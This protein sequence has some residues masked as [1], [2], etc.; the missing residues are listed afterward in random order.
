VVWFNR[1]EGAHDDMTP[2]TDQAPD[3]QSQRGRQRAFVGLVATSSAVAA[4]VI[5]AAQQQPLGD[6]PLA[7]I[8]CGCLL[9]GLAGALRLARSVPLGLASMV[10]FPAWALLDLAMNGGHNLLPLELAIYAVYGGLG[11]AVAA[12]AKRCRG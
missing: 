11:V 9:A 5:G 4:I 3:A 6:D 10:G 12:I 7:M 8:L 1:R 2:T